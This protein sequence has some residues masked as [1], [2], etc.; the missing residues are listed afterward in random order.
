[1]FCIVIIND[2][3]HESVWEFFFV[4]VDMEGKFMRL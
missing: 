4:E 2:G 1:M 3:V